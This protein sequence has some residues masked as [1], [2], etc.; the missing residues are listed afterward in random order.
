MATQ[1]KI[2]TEVLKELDFAVSK[3]PTWP[4][5][6]LHALSVLGEEYGELNKAVLQLVYEPHKTS[7]E[8][9]NKE[10]IQTAAMAIRFLIS[11]DVYSFN[12]STQHK[13]GE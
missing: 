1:D 4:D 13:Q 8:E 7:Y 5:D 2:I 10:A 11:L 3:F 6:P 9:V 12:T